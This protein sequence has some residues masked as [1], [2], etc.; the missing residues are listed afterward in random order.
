M[1]LSA[2][3]DILLYTNTIK[4]V[5]HSTVDQ[6]YK[7]VSLSTVEQHYKYVPHST[8]CQR[9]KECVTFYCRPTL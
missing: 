5:L 2:I 8:V 1:P 4:N 6:H 3:F 9:Y 7:Y